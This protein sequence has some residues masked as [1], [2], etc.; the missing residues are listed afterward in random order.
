MRGDESQLGPEGGG[1]CVMLRIDTRYVLPWTF[2]RTKLTL[3]NFRVGRY[4]LHYIFYS[5][6]I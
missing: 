5:Q 1:G 6:G 3:W 2:M 4:N